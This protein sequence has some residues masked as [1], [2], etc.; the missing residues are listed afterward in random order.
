MAMVAQAQTTTQQD[1]T[2]YPPN[3]T[4]PGGPTYYTEY[5]TGVTSGLT[6]GTT[7]QF[8]NGPNGAN[9]PFSPGCTGPSASA[10]YYRLTVAGVGSQNNMI[11]FDLTAPGPTSEV[12]GDFDFRM[13]EQVGTHADGIGVALLPTVTYGATGPGPNITEEA[14]QSTTS[15]GTIGF[16]LDTYNNGLP[17]DLGDPNLPNGSDASELSVNYN[18]SSSLMVYAVDLYALPIGP[19]NSPAAYDLHN[20]NMT[21]CSAFDHCHFTV[22]FNT[23]PGA[24]IVTVTITSNQPPVTSSAIDANPYTTLQP[25]T[26]LPPIVGIVPGVTPYEMRLGF[27][28][29]TGGA[30][31]SN[32][33]TNVFVTFSP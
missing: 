18:S 8:S 30:Y 6:P 33:I 5:G 31:D 26:A 10:S 16:G 1:F 19:G 22:D 4:T 27:G 17:F 21:D 3:P 29:R 7:G 11:A 15:S 13:G 25:G 9:A 32:D 28:G 23:I 20:D 12:T 2:V 14:D 24:A